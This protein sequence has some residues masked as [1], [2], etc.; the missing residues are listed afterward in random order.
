[1]LHKQNKTRQKKKWKSRTKTFK[2]IKTKCKNV[3]K[4]GTNQTTKNKMQ[5]DIKAKENKM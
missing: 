1:M 5:D 4:Y 3:R 2:Q